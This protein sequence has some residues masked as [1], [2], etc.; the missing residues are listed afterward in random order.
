MRYIVTFLIGLLSFFF[1]SDLYGRYIKKPNH[2]WIGLF[3]ILAS[4]ATFIFGRQV[5]YSPLDELTSTFLLGAGLGTLIHHL[6]SKQY[7]FNKAAEQQFATRHKYA[8]ERFWEILPGA[9][10]WIGLTSPIWL[11]FTL[12]YAVAYLIILATAYWMINAIRLAVLLFLGYRKMEWAKS[13][14]W[15]DL[16]KKAYPNT[17][18]NYYHLVVI[19]TYKESL[20]VL[21][22]AFNAIANSN[23]PKDKIFLAVGFEAWAPEEQTQDKIKYLQSYKD[24]LAGVFT[25]IHQ[26]LRGELKGPATNRNCIIRNAEKQFAK[27]KIRPEQVMVTTLDADFCI[28]QEFLSGM[29]HKYLST[30][31]SVRNKRSFTGAFLY[32]NNYWQTPAPM[33]LIAVGTA[34]WQ[35]AEMYSSDKYMNF[36]S[37]S[38]N[39]QSLLDIGLWMPDK[40]ND[41]SGFFWK[42]YF[43]FNGNYKVIPHYL[44]INGDA[45]LDT[46]IAKTFQNQYLQLKRWAYGVEHVPYVFEN[47]FTN[48]R[49]DFWDKTDKLIFALWGYLRWGMLALFV[50]FAGLFIPLINKDYTE[51]ALSINLP[52]VSSWMLTIAFLGLFSTVYVHERT[53]PP[54]PKNWGLLQRIWSYLQWLLLPLVMITIST[55]PA[56]DAQTS[57]MLNHKL[58]FRTTIKARKLKEPA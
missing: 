34:F 7:L 39:M 37:M 47:Y 36:S 2:S 53:V 14:P 48:T 56:I 44:T 5:L 21:T 18:Q 51:S 30:P 20:E 22:P 43:H 13:E 32:Y 24:K 29:L 25:T 10:T 8:I 26:L 6:L 19:P 38:M 15:L 45:V 4:V 52:I 23:Y 27:L 17:W 35:L 58:E 9:L 57:L 12:P 11:S 54:R 31:E 42:A 1:L 55:I 28:H 16:L 33:R 3:L 50:T 49:L 41:D 40:V 46:T